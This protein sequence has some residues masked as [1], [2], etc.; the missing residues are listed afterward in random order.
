MS[1]TPEEPGTGKLLWAEGAG[2]FVCRK[3]GSVLFISKNRIAADDYATFSKPAVD[4]GVV[5][6]QGYSESGEERAQLLC[7]GCER[8]VGHIGAMSLRTSDDLETGEE[9]REFKVYSEAVRF[10]PSSVIGSSFVSTKMLIAGVVFVAAAAVF[11]VVWGIASNSGFGGKDGA[12]ARFWLNGQELEAQVVELDSGFPVLE[13]K[14]DVLSGPLLLVLPDGEDVALRIRLASGP[15]ELLWLDP[16]FSTAGFVIVDPMVD[17]TVLP[18]ATAAYGLAVPPGTV[19]EAAKK[20]N[21]EITVMNRS[22]FL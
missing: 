10:V 4:G 9:Q 7:G 6:V 12:V 20:T 2:D 1:S 22:A 3:C 19:P 15:F 5:E 8:P 14:P 13:N 18:P 11:W 17:D 16:E 21:F